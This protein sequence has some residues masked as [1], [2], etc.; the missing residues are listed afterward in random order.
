[1]NKKKTVGSIKT[2]PSILKLKRIKTATNK[3]STS[4]SEYFE[5]LQRD[6]VLS[7]KKL[8]WKIVKIITKDGEHIPIGDNE[9]LLLTYKSKKTKPV[10][11]KKIKFNKKS[12]L[13]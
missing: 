9:V 2:V 1:M 8:S 13:I 12:L 7:E 6:N 5:K 10:N 11:H 4:P 3:Y